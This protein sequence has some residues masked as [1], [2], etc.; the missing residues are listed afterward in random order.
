VSADAAPFLAIKIR[1]TGMEEHEQIQYDKDPDGQPYTYLSEDTL[2]TFELD[3]PSTSNAALQNALDAVWSIENTPEWAQ[4]LRVNSAS[5]FY[6]FYLPKGYELCVGQVFS[7]DIGPVA[8]VDPAKA[9]LSAVRLHFYLLH[10]ETNK[11]PKRICGRYHRGAI[12]QCTYC[13][14]FAHLCMQHIDKRPELKSVMRRVR[15]A[16]IHT[17]WISTTDTRYMLWFKV[18]LMEAEKAH[19]IAKAMRQGFYTLKRI[20][21]QLFLIEKAKWRDDDDDCFVDALDS[22][23]KIELFRVALS[24]EFIGDRVLAFE[25]DDLTELDVAIN[26]YAQYPALHAFCHAASKVRAHSGQIHF[27]YDPNPTPPARLRPDYLD[28]CRGT[29]A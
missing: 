4:G 8:A 14:A 16:Q 15:I 27:S 20:E 13:R 1:I 10:P 23:H 22:F 6:L 25:G 9:D 11:K 2:C 28:N 7:L 17:Q 12:Q 24:V 26:E 21:E 29:P 3:D 19:A 5:S 18:K